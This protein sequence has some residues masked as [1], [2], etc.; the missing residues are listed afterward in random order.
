[1]EGKMEDKIDAMTTALAGPAIDSSQE[2]IA[3]RKDAQA[4]ASQ[5][6]TTTTTTA[7]LER[8]E[9]KATTSA[10]PVAPSVEQPEPIAPIAQPEQV[11][12]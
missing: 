8:N 5:E 10:L 1:M 9:E 12:S 3:E 4:A 2:L 6:L 7:R 11:R